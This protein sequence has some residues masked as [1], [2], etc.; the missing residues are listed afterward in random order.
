MYILS[1]T[2]Y[3]IEFKSVHIESDKEGTNFTTLMQHCLRYINILSVLKQN[4]EANHITFV[5][6]FRSADILHLQLQG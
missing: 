2:D 3:G 5:G 6:L 1:W 4:S